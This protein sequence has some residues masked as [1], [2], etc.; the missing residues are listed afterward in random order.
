MAFAVPFGQ[1]LPDTTP[2]HVCD[3]RTKLLIVVAYTFAL[4]ASRSWWAMALLA[5][6]M[7]LGYLVAHVPFKIA[8]RGLKPLAV[9]LVFTVAANAFTFQATTLEGAVALWGSF[10]CT[11]PG[12]LDGLYFALRICLLVLATSLITFTTTMVGLVDALTT[13]MGPLRRLH[14]PVDD[15]ATMFSIALRFIPITAEEADKVVMAQRARGVRFDEGGPIVRV[16]KWA[17]VLIPLFVSLFRRA[18]ELASAMEARCYT[19][20]G[21]V[22]LNRTVMRPSDWAALIVLAAACIAIGILL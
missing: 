15:I 6:G 5:L 11:L 21:R 7:L 8:L 18:D 22:R 14:V 4:F 16:R 2:V 19:G 9:I 3:A 20:L 17:V 10:G 1:Y 12:L 13:L